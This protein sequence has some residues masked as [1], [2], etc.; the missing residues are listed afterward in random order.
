MVSDPKNHISALH[1]LLCPDAL[2]VA[3][4]SARESDQPSREGLKELLAA[5]VAAPLVS[6]LSKQEQEEFSR[7]DRCLEVLVEEF[8]SR[9]LELLRI[10]KARKSQIESFIRARSKLNVT[11][12]DAVQSRLGSPEQEA[13]QLFAHQACVFHLLQIILVKR[14]VDRGLLPPQ[15]LKL[16]EQTLNWQITSF[17]RKNSP[18]GMM[19]RHDW[20]FLKQNL[21][22][23]FS[24][25]KET[26]ERLRLLLEPVNLAE[27]SGDFPARL[28]R[29]LG[30][31]S[32]LSLLGFNPTLIDS[33]ALWKLL[34]EQKAFDL[35][36]DSTAS[37]DFSSEASG[38][39]LVSGLKNGESLNALRELSARK[40][41]HGA[42]AFT[43]SDFERYLSEMFIL[44]DCASEIPRINIH[45][46]SV[47]RELSRDATKAASLFADG[48]K[49]PHQA[50]F[51]ACFQDGEGEE[52]ED[53]T[54]LLD[55]LRE[56]GLLLVASDLFWPTDANESCERMREAVL[57][58]ASVRL[59]IDLRQLTGNS[60]ESLPKGVFL[61][62]KCSSKEL[63][64]SNRPQILRARGH[65]Q[66][67]QVPSAWQAILEHIRNESS[68]G[69]VRVRSLSS[70]GEGV[71]L[72][73]M[74][75]AASQQE[76]RSSPWI[77][78][79]D[80]AFYEAS[81]RLR[82]SPNKAYTLGTIMRWKQGMPAP[83]PRSVLLQEQSKNLLAAL[84]GEAA[85]FSVETPEYFFL[86]DSSVVE[87]PA[88]YLAQVYSAPVQFWYRLELEQNAG[89]RLKQLERQ[90]EQRLKL[91]PLV[92][93]FEPGTLVP[94][95][96]NTPAP[97]ESMQVVRNQLQAVFRH[98]N[99]GMSEKSK[100]HE[101]ILSLE[102]SVKKN[103]DVCADFARHLFPD[104]EIRRWQV[105][106]QLPEISPT[107]SL[108]IF[109]HLDRSPLLQHPSIHVTKLR[110]AHDF[111]V[112]NST[113]EEMPLG[114]LGELKVFHGMDP[115]LKLNG[116]SLL[117]KAATEEIQKRLGRPWRETAERILF[118]TD[119]ILVQTQ[120][121][122]VV[123]SIESQLHLTREH[124][125]LIDQIFCCLF[126][127]SN[128]FADESVRIAL[129]RHLSPD[130]SKIQV[131]FQK[132]MLFRPTGLGVPTEL[133]Q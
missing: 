87:H 8:L 91:M 94:V 108:D 24:P 100:L 103:L 93:L 12:E 30:S 122:D 61:L 15:S 41:L 13:L 113:F 11:L 14:W 16:S 102:H 36:L 116:P 98:S 124:L 128:S 34:L 127:L 84:P 22:S 10:N 26:W 4:R 132:E 69:E 77:T 101:I 133:L 48:L 83:S 60:G 64:D 82:R 6:S 23:W 78:L 18:K 42:W 112:T 121:K 129:R 104:L 92:R 35:R 57:R 39:V 32:R 81:G 109:R 89:K 52:L 9:K 130:E 126:G 110:T 58:K 54:F 17:L 106:S 40:E 95:Q 72:E 43:D 80:P 49:V 33:G 73:A 31:R 85:G 68:P 125:A 114:A 105:P 131:R 118:P 90:T 123:K 7:W 88:Y 107:L 97:I 25:S 75:A 2:R 46:R 5:P 21:F 62:E 96:N 70:L 74:A 27:E 20:S 119:F 55:Q 56:N 19:A 115:V 111:K 67:Q 51:G 99:L 53:A 50:Q 37:L 28:L 45:P 3:L 117:L 65:L 29:S 120:L 38:P 66:K 63:R 59:I 71:R 1:G 47:L 44:W 76:L 79:A 86:P